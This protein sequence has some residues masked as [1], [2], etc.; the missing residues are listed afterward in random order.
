MPKI[1]KLE[2]KKQHKDL[3]NRKKIQKKGDISFSTLQRVKDGLE[4]QQQ[5]R[6]K[7][8]HVQS[9]YDRYAEIKK[10]QKED[11]EVA[12]VEESAANEA[13]R[14]QYFK[15]FKKVVDL[16]D[17]LLEVL[18]IRDPMGCRSPK[19]ENY[20]LKRGK[21]VVLILNKADLVP[22]EIANKW[23]TFLRREFPT[24][25]FKSTNNPTKATYVP[26]HDGK[27]R[28][29]DCF[30]VEELIIL[31][32]KYSGGSHITAGIIGSPNV[33][34]SSVINSLSRRSA[35]GV[36][37]TPG[38]TRVMQEIEVTSRIKILDSPGVI[39]SSG[40]EISPSMV[41]RNSIKIELL[42]DPVQPVSFILDKVPKEQLMELYGINT[43][44]DA[45]DFLTQ[46]AQKRGKLHKGGEAD[47]EAMARMVLD[48]W[49][50]GHIR[51]YTIP[52]ETDDTI[53]AST[54]LVTAN[55]EVYNMGRQINLTE[56]DFKNF[57]IRHVFE[58]VQKNKK[59]NK[60]QQ[61]ISDD[62]EQNEEPKHTN[63][64]L[65]NEQKE[66]LDNL[67]Q[68]FQGISFTGL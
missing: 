66:E 63:V 53:E 11:P 49:N 31:L 52:P 15:Q 13:Y 33:G 17:V 35:A 12:V 7:S 10:A 58:I 38:F 48:D 36:G 62:E 41:L 46:L 8:I 19:L 25:L 21:R 27:W 39:A 16:S 20:I 43:F 5:N 64:T 6:Q 51:Y 37:S 32:N 40:L 42:E 56:Q 14:T 59:S 28:S 26:L 4:K 60:N 45:D 68:E 57:Q 50:K 67:A 9:K 23:L 65:D 54:E 24:V 18:D 2:K 1:P 44:S 29:T 47:I 22:T 55:G 61:E 3:K 30:G 34:K